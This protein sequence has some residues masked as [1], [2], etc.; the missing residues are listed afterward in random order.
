MMM[1]LPLR[2]Y[3]ACVSLTDIGVPL[4]IKFIVLRNCCKSVF[5]LLGKDHSC[6]E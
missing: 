3:T 6:L 5:Y 2:F 4:K 1:I